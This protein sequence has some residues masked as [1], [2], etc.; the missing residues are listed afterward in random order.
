MDLRTGEHLQFLGL[1]QILELTE[2]HK[3]S[4]QIVPSLN[5]KVNILIPH[6][7]FRWNARD[8]QARIVGNQ[9]VSECVEMVVSSLALKLAQ[10][11]LASD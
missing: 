9:A 4:F 7:F 2:L 11:V 3:K 6:C 1:S 10:V 5:N 8:V